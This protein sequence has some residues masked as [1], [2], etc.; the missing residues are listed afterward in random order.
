MSNPPIH[1]LRLAGLT[2]SIWQNPA[3]NQDTP[4]YT[5]TL[6]RAYKDKDD[7]WQQVQNFRQQDLL[8]LSKLAN[9]A[10]DWINA[11]VAED[12]QAVTNQTKKARAKQR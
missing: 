12:R 6:S 5:T 4:Y 8:A 3:K 10:H 7:E 1:R 9:Q 11:Q 2:A